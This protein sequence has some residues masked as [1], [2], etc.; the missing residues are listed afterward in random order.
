MD[1]YEKR[2]RAKSMWS[3]VMRQYDLKLPYDE[4]IDLDGCETVEEI[5]TM[6]FDYATRVA[7]QQ[8]LLMGGEE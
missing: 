1:G 5:M 7:E 2:Q 6:V 8:K 3:T 4:H